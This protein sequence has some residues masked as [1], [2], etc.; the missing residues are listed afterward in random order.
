MSFIF[1]DFIVETPASRA[2]AATE[3]VAQGVAHG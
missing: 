2:L 3:N 1:S